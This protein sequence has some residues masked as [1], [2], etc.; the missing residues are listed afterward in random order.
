MYYSSL[1]KIRL[2]ASR[3]KSAA[4]AMALLAGLPALASAA[5]FTW[6]GGGGD[7]NWSTA[8]NWV[9]DA[10]PPND[11]T[12]DIV[13]AGST[14]ITPNVDAA[15]NIKSL[16]FNGSSAFTLSGSD[17]TIQG[18][19][20]MTTAGITSNI[21]TATETINNNLILGTTQS[22]KI[23]SGATAKLVINGDVTSNVAF[24]ALNAAGVIEVNGVMGGTGNFSKDFNGTVVLNDAN[25]LTG[26]PSNATAFNGTVLVGVNTPNGAPGA[27]GDS[28]AAI[29]LGAGVAG[30]GTVSV[31]TSAAVA[32]DRAFTVRSTTTGVN[33]ITFGGSTADTSTFSNTISLGSASA[34]ANAIT[35]T[36]ATGGRVNFTGNLVRASGA[37]GT[38]DTV[39]KIGD[40]TVVLAG[41][42]NTYQGTTTVSVGTLLVNGTLDNLGAAVSVASAATLGGNGTI[43][44]AV[45]IAGGG[46]LSAG[47]MSGATSL[48]GTLA[49][50]TGATSGL[51]LLDT[52]VLKFDLQQGNFTIGGGVNDLVTV[53]GA[54]T[55]DGVL[56][57]T[58]LGGTLT[59]GTYVLFTYTGALT[60]NALTIDSAFLTNHA[61]STI[62]TS[63][64]N[65]V[66]LNVVPEPS[67][68]A[69]LLLGT[70]GIAILRLSSNRR[71]DTRN[72]A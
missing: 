58:E 10:A 34:K 26:N 18:S 66:T 53:D 44:R 2:L 51:S 65:Q 16:T 45:A 32:V 63:V 15:W 61:G 19:G 54:L 38:T 68:T 4:L 57:V 64:A 47:D 28:S 21:S 30:T 17:L 31:L 50:G 6:D 56:Q 46:I 27:F 24:Q 9:G 70:L 13:L 40:G 5:T 43:N 67:T 35:L 22:W 42:A 49:L 71:A 60:D 20:V 62:D 23:P 33:T 1:N 14:R 11:G 12:A 39:T 69:F 29:L 55:L 8:A 7:N 36:A 37:T 59:G 3:N 25:T 52:S 72:A 48:A 41:S